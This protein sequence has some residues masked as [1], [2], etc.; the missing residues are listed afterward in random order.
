M[1]RSVW[2]WRVRSNPLRR[3][4][5][6]V[7]AW[8]VL[9]AALVTTAGAVATGAVVADDVRHH[10]DQQRTQRHAMAAVLAQDAT[11]RAG[12]PSDSFALVSWTTPDGTRHSARADVGAARKSGDPVTVWTDSRGRL[13]P[14][15]LD[16]TAARLQA[17]TDGAAAGVAAGGLGLLGCGI[18]ARFC[19]RRRTEEWAAEWTVVG[20]RWD[21]RTA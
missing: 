17:A 3:R 21:H 1:S 16:A 19:E 13:T 9:A 8:A 4:S 20:P 10:L 6:A 2:L 14:A 15:P 12:Y 11:R 18:A 5:Y 7:E